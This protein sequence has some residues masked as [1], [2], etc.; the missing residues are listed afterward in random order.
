MIGTYAS[1]IR[2]LRPPATSV[3]SVSVQKEGPTQTN[4]QLNNCCSEKIRTDL[5]REGVPEKLGRELRPL[6]EVHRTDPRGQ[7]RLF[8][9]EKA[10]V[11]ST[12]RGKNRLT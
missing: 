10:A 12:Q 11:V 9:E 7:Q 6:D 3:A 8:A 2:T 4:E 5:E 1:Y